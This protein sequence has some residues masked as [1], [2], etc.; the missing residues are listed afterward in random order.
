[1][2]RPRENKQNNFAEAETDEMTA[3]SSRK[4]LSFQ[5]RCRRKVLPRNTLIGACVVATVALFSG[6]PSVQFAHA[7]SMTANI[8]TP[9]F[10][11]NKDTIRGSFLQHRRIEEDQSSVDEAVVEP[12][13][14]EE[15]T[16]CTQC[17][18]TEINTYEACAETGKW[19]KFKCSGPKEDSDDGAFSKYEMKSC[20]HT[21]FENGVAMF[22]FQIFCVL[23][24][25]LSLVS[26]KKQKKL[27][28]SMFDR[29]KQQGSNNGGNN[30]TV[31]SNKRSDEEEN[32]EFTPMTNQQRERV[33]LVARMEVI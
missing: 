24:G 32:I 15:V 11:D 16:R 6:T 2:K 9:T 21:D 22:Q 25:F 14:T 33:P 8:P 27:S 18:F 31:R 17:T 7:S 4:Q 13:C 3:S 29:R 12:V 23:I 19:Q 20:K 30:T 26:V 1:M 5:H 10:L 28:L